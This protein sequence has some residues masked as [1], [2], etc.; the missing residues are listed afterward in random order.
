MKLHAAMVEKRAQMVSMFQLKC[1]LDDRAAAETTKS[2]QMFS[3]RFFFFNWTNVFIDVSSFT[4]LNTLTEC[5]LLR[6][7]NYFVPYLSLKKKKKGQKKEKQH[8][9]VVPYSYDS[10]RGPKIK[11]NDWINNNDIDFLYVFKS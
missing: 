5:F 2:L 8:E 1:F 6:A 4:Y 10:V 11:I 3:I 9:Q 7:L